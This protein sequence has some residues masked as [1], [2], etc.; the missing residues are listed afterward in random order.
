MA[1]LNVILSLNWQ[2]LHSFGLEPQW[3]LPAKE[4]K[5]ALQEFHE[6]HGYGSPSR[7]IQAV[8]RRCAGSH[9]LFA[10]LPSSRLGRS[11]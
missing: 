9:C 11:S 7:V 2:R 10:P 1:E 6:M 5:Q 4:S 8:I 3:T